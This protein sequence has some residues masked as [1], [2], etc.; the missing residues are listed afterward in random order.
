MDILSKSRPPRAA[1]KAHVALTLVLDVSG[2]MSFKSDEEKNSPI[3][4]LNNGINEMIQ[5]LKADS[6]LKEI[7]DLSIFT[8]GEQCKENPYLAFRAIMDVDTV[9]LV[10]ND[11]HT[12]IVKAL[13]EAVEATRQRC[14]EYSVGCYK[15]WIIVITDGYF[16]DNEVDL[17]T[18]GQLMKN[19]AKDGK[20]HFFGFGVGKYNRSQLEKFCETEQTA[21]RVVDMKA[22]KFSELFS[23]IGRSMK[24]VSDKEITSG[25]DVENPAMLHLK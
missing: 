24:R 10:A 8:F 12:Y 4:L 20:Q 15:P 5:G 16:H 22:E 6:R 21:S 18:V 13:E 25:V 23:W 3:D 19:R 11:T 1:S 17:D 14:A 2:S 9:Q 7:I